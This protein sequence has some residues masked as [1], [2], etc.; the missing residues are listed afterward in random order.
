MEWGAGKE[1][2]E[3]LG[4]GAMSHGP[5]GVTWRWEGGRPKTP[6]PTPG[7]VTPGP[8]SLRLEDNK[9]ASLNMYRE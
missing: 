7:C 4:T 3:T 6:A 8:L 2:N 1:R 5:D 9:N